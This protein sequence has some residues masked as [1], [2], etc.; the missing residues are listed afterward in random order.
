MS[1][2]VQGLQ[3]V[4]SAATDLALSASSWDVATEAV[5]ET[6]HAVG[7]E[8]LHTAHQKLMA[9]TG[10][11]PRPV[12]Q[13]FTATVGAGDDFAVEATRFVLDT[14][15]HPEDTILPV[16]VVGAFGVVSVSGAIG[17]VLVNGVAKRVTGHGLLG[18]PFVAARAISN[19]YYFRQLH[20][21]DSDIRYT[22]VSKLTA[23]GK[24][25][26]AAQVLVK[27]LVNTSDFNELHNYLSCLRYMPFKVTRGT[28]GLCKNYLENAHLVT[29]NTIDEAMFMHAK[30]QDA[31][32]LIADHSDPENLEFLSEFLSK[33]PNRPWCNDRALRQMCIGALGVDPQT[34]KNVLM[35]EINFFAMEESATK[36]AEI[37]LYANLSYPGLLNETEHQQVSE[38][39]RR[40]TLRKTP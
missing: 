30:V 17:I 2:L 40:N 14:T 1:C 32:T 21:Q 19:A 36:A 31:V 34:Y 28:V 39:Y 35:R 18:L 20:S 22:A 15:A 37:L 25:E 4:G 8:A 9:K 26:E 6:A 10:V 27:A 29:L 33:M 24:A 23:R 16:L 13:E 7:R 3:I 12:R 5:E 38:L 11:K